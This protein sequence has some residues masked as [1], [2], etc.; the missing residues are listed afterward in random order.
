MNG[1]GQK[2]KLYQPITQKLSDIQNPVLVVWGRKDGLPL[3]HGEMVAKRV[4]NGQLSI[5]E[6]CGHSPMF[7]KPQEFYPIVHDFL[8]S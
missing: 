2:K 4:K 8:K 3:W 6:D 5:I 7:E 1:I